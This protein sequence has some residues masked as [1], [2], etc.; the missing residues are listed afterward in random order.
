MSAAESEIKQEYS[1]ERVATILCVDDEPQIL[2]SLERLFRRQGYSVITATGGPEALQILT[3][4]KI[5]LV[6][7]DMR[8]PEMTGA[9]LLA[10]SAKRWPDIV[11]ILL[12]G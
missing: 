11:R 4:K 8:M 9:E 2:S 12:T 6:I 10:E 7:S 3:E 5:D 1:K